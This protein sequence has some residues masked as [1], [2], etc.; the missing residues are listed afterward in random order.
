[1]PGN[2]FLKR[3]NY[4]K[5]K[6]YATLR[7][8]DPNFVPPTAANASAVFAQNG[9][10]QR[11]DEA[12]ENERIAKREKAD[13]DEE[14]MEIDD[15]EESPQK[16]NSCTS[17]YLRSAIYTSFTKRL[18]KPPPQVLFQPKCNI[19]LR[20]YYVQIFRKKWRTM[21]CRYCFNSMPSFNAVC[22]IWANKIYRYKGFQTTNVTWSPTPNHDG[23][24]V[25][26]A[27]VIFESPELASSAKEALDGF[28]LKKGWLMS[29]VYI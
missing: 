10:R 16:Q 15:E 13:E 12:A 26:M 9:K 18:R 14:E 17:C 27:Q 1:M 5:S 8:E 22:L 2:K 24:R 3:I 6:S 11:D 7:K 28:T 23:V 29:V 21:C 20:V 25:K 4:A 19:L